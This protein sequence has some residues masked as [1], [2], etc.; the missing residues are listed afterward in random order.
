MATR[1]LPKSFKD[2][3]TSWIPKARNEL[4]LKASDENKSSS[5]NQEILNKDQDIYSLEPQE[6]TKLLNLWPVITAGVGLFSDGYINNSISTVSLCL[7]NIY[8]TQYSDSTAISYVSAIAFAGTVLG[9]LSFGYI[10]DYYSRKTGMM[11]STAILILFSILCAGAWGVGTSG[12]NAGTLFAVIAAY[13]FLM[14]IGIGGE[15]PAGSVACSEASNSLPPSKRNRWFVLFTLFMIDFGFVIAAFVP[16]VLLWI[17]T[18]DHLQPVW[19]VTIGL[20]AIMPISLFFLRLKWKESK[21]FQTLN[22]KKASIPYWSVLK[23]YWL[24]LM[25]CSICWFLYDFTSYAF[26]SYSTVIIAEV[27]PEGNMYQT[28]GWNVVFNLFLIPGAFLG[29]FSCDYIGPRLTM[30][31][32]FGLQ[33]I[34]GY[35][36]AGF[37][38]PLKKHIAAFTVIYGLFQSLGEFGPGGTTIIVSSKTCAT[39]IRGQYFGVAAAIGKVGAF[40]GTYA[41]PIIKKKY[42]D[43]APFW[44][45]SSLALTGA[46]VALLLLPEI[47]KDSTIQED[48]AFMK[49]LESENYDISKIMA[50]TYTDLEEN[51]SVKSTKKDTIMVQVNTLD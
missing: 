51:D 4:Y 41:F 37:Y 17:C 40:S 28:F 30:A 34:I 36:F 27:I 14:G 29:A 49:Y 48:R 10:S 22:L 11:I 9:Q 13:R 24:R 39:P 43:S 19:R 8:G 23:F 25:V 16:M 47:S 15:Y 3:L 38:G 6:K 20:G 33:G 42:G 18:P 2:L 12:T 44:V 21:E 32:G 35:L 1:D 46:I 31:L 26:S 7:S 45:S 50:V 5:F